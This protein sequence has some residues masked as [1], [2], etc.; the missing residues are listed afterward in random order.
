MDVRSDKHKLYFISL[1]IF[2]DMFQVL[3]HFFTHVEEKMRYFA[4]ALIYICL[5]SKS[6]LTLRLKA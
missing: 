6:N 1:D 5:W 4:S 3:T 2:H